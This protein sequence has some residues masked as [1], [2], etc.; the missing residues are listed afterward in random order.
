MKDIYVEVKEYWY[1]AIKDIDA[2]FLLPCDYITD[3]YEE[4]QYLFQI[5]TALY[6]KIIGRMHENVLL[7]YSAFLS[8]M[9]ILF[10]KLTGNEI[11][12]ISSPVYGDAKYNKVIPFSNR[13]SAN[14]TFREVV[15]N[16]NVSVKKGYLYQFYPLDEIIDINEFRDYEKKMK[17]FMLFYGEIHSEAL[18][19][20]FLKLNS[21]DFTIALYKSENK[22]VGRVFYNHLR[23]KSYT[24]KSYIDSYIIIINQIMDNLNVRIKDFSLCD[25]KKMRKP[26]CLDSNNM[27]RKFYAHVA[28]CPEAVAFVDGERSI[29][30]EELER[31]SNQIAYQLSKY[32]IVKGSTVAIMTQ[33]AIDAV[34]GMIATVKLGLV[35]V[36]VNP[37][38]TEQ[39]IR[40]L[41]ED[42]KCNY[43]LLDNAYINITGI[44]VIPIV[45]EE[46]KENVR[47]NV[48]ILMEDMIGILY[49]YNEHGHLF[50]IHIT[51]E[52]IVKGS[53]FFLEDIGYEEGERMAL[54]TAYLWAAPIWILYLTL[55][56]KVPLYII[57][58]SITADEIAL[59]KYLK[60]HNITISLGD[61]K[62]TQLIVKTNDIQLKSV[63]VICEQLEELKND[64]SLE[65]AV[66]YR[67]FE[68]YAVFPMIGFYEDAGSKK[69]ELWLRFKYCDR[70]SN[71]LIVDADHMPVGN[72][73]PGELLFDIEILP[74]YGIRLIARQFE[75]GELLIASNVVGDAAVN[76]EHQLVKDKSFYL[77][78]ENIEKQLIVL[79]EN[80]FGVDKI[81]KDRRFMEQGGNSI[82]LMRLVAE[83]NKLY[84]NIVK[85]SD[86]FI[87]PSI[88][89]LANY[90]ATKRYF[91]KKEKQVGDDLI[92]SITTILPSDYYEICDKEYCKTLVYQFERKC[93]DKIERILSKLHISVYT[94]FLAVFSYVILRITKLDRIFI[95]YFLDNAH[96]IGGIEVK[97][98]WMND[99]NYYFTQIEHQMQT[100]ETLYNLEDI[101]HIRMDEKVKK[102]LILFY[103]TR[104]YRYEP[105]IQ[106]LYSIILG[107]KKSDYDNVRIIYRWSNQRINTEKAK[108]L[109]YIIISCIQEMTE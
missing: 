104:V 51:Q 58:N 87:Y 1:R 5:H 3:G 62:L 107:V 60:K 89:S 101:K 90:I 54:S 32:N 92:N 45:Y 71:Y 72:G 91:M 61:D 12:S 74:E 31:K 52:Q 22:I 37:A 39:Y 38:G 11:N 96:N 2:D 95:N 65:G 75:E 43:I 81:D 99:M 15:Q 67:I 13:V 106:A 27:I 84:P 86:I 33:F 70:Y 77:H 103:D 78:R 49:L 16:V 44:H 59:N 14:M 83:V 56:L 73:V 41:L 24:I 7:E 34:I 64:Y 30:Y 100:K 82:L 6:E 20:D 88:T 46:K 93:C 55:V 57:P 35:F 26:E 85:I 19:A 79:L 69:E 10:Y 50:S 66:I 76:N 80:V 18:L 48:E 40:S 17:K 94:F 25:L 105:E 108:E 21:N 8:A 102:S 53:G 28:T 23:Y 36:L 42:S 4:G 47:F 109:F 63:I 68:P 9:Y 98:E 29:T 97:Y